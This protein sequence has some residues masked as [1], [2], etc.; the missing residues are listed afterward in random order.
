MA[1]TN[2]EGK[3]TKYALGLITIPVA[4]SKPRDL[5]WTVLSDRTI[6]L[7]AQKDFLDMAADVL[8]RAKLSDH[9]GLIGRFSADFIRKKNAIYKEYG[10]ATYPGGIPFEI[11]YL[12]GKAE[13]F[14]ETLLPLGFAGVE[15]SA[16][17][18]PPIPRKKRTELIKAAKRLGLE[19][20]T[21]VG[22]KLSH[23]AIKVDHAIESIQGDLDAG[24]EKVAIE[25]ND[26]VRLFKHNPDAIVQIV[27]GVGLAN[28]SFE[29]GPGGWP[30]MPGW[31]ISQFGADINVQNIFT[32]QIVPFEAI[33]RGLS[34]STGFTFLMNHPNR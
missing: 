17:T 18:I 6:P 2:S 9:T 15:I 26:L 32:D 5:R 19:V 10:I 3:V 29:I 8:D 23:E 27:N 13:P 24:A 33:R 30:E 1:R 25:N 31:L 34:R 4:R 11:A 14:F 21:E 28:V 7:G 16:D 22:E 12:E 20:H